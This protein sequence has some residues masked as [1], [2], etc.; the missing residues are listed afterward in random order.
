MR[1]K[2][3]VITGTR[4]EYGV[5]TPLLREILKTRDLRLQLLVTGMHLLSEFGSTISLIK[6]DGFPISASFEMYDKKDGAEEIPNALCRAIAGCTRAFKRLKPDIVLLEGDRLEMLAAAMASL[7]FRIPLVH[8]SGGDISGGLDDSI[9]HAL[10]KFSHIHLANTQA[11]AVRIKRMGEEPWRIK[12]VGTL[13]VSK[14]IL[15]EAASIEALHKFIP[16]DCRKP[17]FL[18]VQHPV[19]DE[20]KLSG[21]QMRQSL[22]AV[23]G[24]KFPVIVMYP[25]CDT[26]SGAMI[27]EIARYKKYP[28]MHVY[29]NLEREVYLGLLKHAAVIIGNSSS[30]IV[31]APFFGTPVINVGSRQSGRE[32]AGN[33]IDT[34]CVTQHIINAINRFKRNNFARIFKNNPYRDMNT[35]KNIVKILRTLKL[36]QKLL[37]KKLV[38]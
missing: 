4:A 14:A 31:E 29:K 30:G 20:A 16:F 1:R 8:V 37:N 5:I 18:V 12:N 7:T 34:A 38:Y 26:G 35:E 11:S 27:R 19:I 28:C 24:F 36:G 21:F 13:A 33:I 2:I 17:Y 32:R 9:R 3:C 6:K 15:R 25:N 10:T 22:E 23:L